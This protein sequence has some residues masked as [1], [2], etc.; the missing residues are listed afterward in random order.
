MPTDAFE[1]LLQL[2]RERGRLQLE[3]VK[4]ILP[5]DSIPVEELA[6]ILVRLEQAGIAVELDD[7]LLVPRH[8]GISPNVVSGAAPGEGMP[9]RGNSPADLRASSNATPIRSAPSAN[10]A[11]DTSGTIYVAVAAVILVLIVVGV[12]ALA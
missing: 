11:D 9:S 10:P 4:Q 7:D 3:D 2:G 5:V 8:P 12:W 6:N 1:R